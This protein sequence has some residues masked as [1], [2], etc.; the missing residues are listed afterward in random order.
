M[1][2]K[3][4]A[5]RGESDVGAVLLSP[6]TRTGQPARHAMASTDMLPWEAGKPAALVGSC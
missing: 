4:G 1:P 2:A 6:G 3:R 5:E